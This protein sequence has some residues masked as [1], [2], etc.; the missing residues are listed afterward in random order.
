MA[1]GEFM[2]S[3]EQLDFSEFP[4]RICNDA[5]QMAMILF[6]A[7]YARVRYLDMQPFSED[8]L[9]REIGD[10]EYD[11]LLKKALKWLGQL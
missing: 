11:V 4:Q 10:G 8:D 2:W 3:P 7:L 1:S 5:E 9:R 6:T